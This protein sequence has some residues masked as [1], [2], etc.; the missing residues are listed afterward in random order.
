[1]G[2]VRQQ[3][4]CSG[5]GGGLTLAWLMIRPMNVDTSLDRDNDGLFRRRSGLS[6]E[7]A[8][9]SSGTVTVYECRRD[10]MV[11]NVVRHQEGSVI[12]CSWTQ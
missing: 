12:Q 4:R 2:K 1:M 5:G 10:G 6:K 9:G 7:K 11:L 8:A 3:Q